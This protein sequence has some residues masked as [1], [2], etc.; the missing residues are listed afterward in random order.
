[1]FASKTITEHL[2]RG[3]IGIAAFVAAAVLGTLQPLLALALLPVALIA[4]RGCP[5]CWTMGLVQT[6]IARLRGTPPAGHCTDGSCHLRSPT[7]TP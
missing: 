2:L 7:Q 6:A 1:M 5:L 4:L 3:A